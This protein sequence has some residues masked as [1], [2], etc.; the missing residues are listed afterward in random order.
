MKSYPPDVREKA[1]LDLSSVQSVLEKAAERFGSRPALEFMGK[2]TSYAELEAL[3]NRAALGFQKLGVGPGVHVGLFLPNTPHYIIA[4]FGVL[5]A[6]GTVVN[7]SPLDALH[8]LQHKIEDS[9]TDI[10][11]GLDLAALYPQ[12]EK[13]LTSTRLKTLVVGEFAEMTA[14]PAPVKAQMTAAGMLAEVKHDDRRLAFRDL[15]DNDGRYTAHPLGDVK[16][17]LAV[18]AYTGGTT[19][20]PKGAMLTHANLTAACSLYMEVMT[21]SGADLLRVG[22][23]RFLCILPLFHIYSLTVVMLLGFRLGAELV[24]HPRFDPAAAAKDI[25]DKKI[26]V[27][28]GVPT[29]HVALLSVPGAEFDGLVVAPAVRLRRS[30]ASARRAAAVRKNRRLPVDRR[31]GHDRNRADR[32][33]HPA[34][35]YREARLLR[36]PLPHHRDEVHRCRRP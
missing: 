30:A 24:L 21:R 6:G 2:R 29:M 14:A 19:G 10:L 27:Y 28:M 18:I 25:V 34:R 32:N 23:E 22:E 9:E 3:A 16:E 20:T 11:V 31:L 13:L 15:I 35:E 4:F 12:A 33:L 5:K 7:Y 8:T 1:P 17:A 26:T 36:D